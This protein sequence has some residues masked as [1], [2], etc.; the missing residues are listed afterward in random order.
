M[1]LKDKIKNDLVRAIKAK[2]ELTRLVLRSLLSEIENK[3]IE[4]K[5]K[6][7]GLEDNEIE[8]I[9]LRE[10]KK[11]AEAEEQFRKGDRPQLMDQEKKEAEILKKYAPKQLSNN[12]IE[13]IIDD[14]IKET[15][16]KEI[17]DM[18]RVIS[19]TMSKVGN[20][21]NGKIV[22]SLVKE[23]LLGI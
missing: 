9:I 6:D 8:Q 22:S 12:E 17:K 23:K 19:A 1:P 11:R 13:K 7:K 4:L 2:N 20:L 21:A 18:G 5:K 10:I 3:A 15:N 16:V 14:I